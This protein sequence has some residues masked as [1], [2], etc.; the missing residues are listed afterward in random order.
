MLLLACCCL[1]AQDN[2]ELAVKEML[3]AAVREH[4]SN[5]LQAEDHLD[6]GSKICLQVTID[7]EQGT[8]VFDFEGE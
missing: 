3:R 4:G 5:V 6:D 1:R 8:A 7:E 2:A